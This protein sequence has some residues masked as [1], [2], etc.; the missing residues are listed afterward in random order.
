MAGVLV[1][2]AGG[3]SCGSSP[4]PRPAAPPISPP[5]GVLAAAS[6]TSILTMLADGSALRTLEAGAELGDVS[7]SQDGRVIAYAAR[8]GLTLIDAGTRVIRHVRTRPGVS[9][10]PLFNADGSRIY[11]LHS[12]SSSRVAYDLWSIEQNGKIVRHTKGADMSM[13]TVSPDEERISFVRDL[14]PGGLGKIH[15][16]D[17]SGR[18][19]TVVARGLQPTFSPDGRSLAYVSGRGI[20][21]VGADGGRSRLVASAGERPAFSADGRWIA[22]LRDATCLDDAYC[23]KRIFLVPVEGGTATAIG[24]ELDDPRRVS[25]IEEPSAAID[26]GDVEP[27]ASHCSRSGDFCYGI[28]IEGDALVLAIDTYARYFDAYRLCVRGPMGEQSCGGFPIREQGRLYGSS[29]RWADSFAD[30]GPGTYVATWRLQRGR[31]GP[32]LRFRLG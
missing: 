18:R 23:R 8:E 25:W 27:V 13:F 5:T 22:F 30:H 10:E 2:M 14:E 1:A 4:E 15:V 29:V 20:E 19:A 17:R 16:S 3:V 9:I 32:P 31:L 6:G 11:F 21:V 24:P 7:W 28:R 26:A 12:R